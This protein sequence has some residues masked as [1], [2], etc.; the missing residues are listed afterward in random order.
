[1]I[2]VNLNIKTPCQPLVLPGRATFA[3]YHEPV[4]WEL[5]NKVMQLSEMAKEYTKTLLFTPIIPP[6]QGS[7]TL[8]QCLLIRATPAIVPNVVIL[9][10]N[11]W[12]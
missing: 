11:S 1:L 6:L 7:G 5:T 8:K 2:K 4:I 10:N 3:T 12:F 9:K